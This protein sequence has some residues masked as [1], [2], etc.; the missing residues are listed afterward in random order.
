LKRAHWKWSTGIA[1]CLALTTALVLALRDENRRIYLPGRTSAGHHQIEDDCG[2]CHQ[3]FS[4]VEQRACL[5]C[6]ADE[7]DGELDAHRPEKFSDPR[8]FWMLERIDAKRCVS[9]HAEHKPDVTRAMSVTAPADFCIACHADVGK[10]RRSHAGFEPAGCA[11]TGC[12]RYHDNGALYEDFIAR[13]LGEPDTRPAP[14][15]HARNA[16]A[17]FVAAGRPLGPALARLASDAPKGT[18][19]DG[20]L[21]DWEASSHARAGVNCGACHAPRGASWNNHPKPAVCKGCHELES[22]GFLAGRHGMRLERGLS[23]MEPA[24]AQLP[25]KHRVEHTELG[26]SSCH[27]AH[28]FD[29][30][31]AAV[32]ACVACHDDRH[33]RAYA[34]TAHDRLWRAEVAGTAP[35]GSGVSCATCHLPRHTVRDHGN[36]LVRVQHNQNDNLRPNDKFVRS[37]CLSCHGLGFSFDALADA[38]LVARNFRGRP[39]RHLTTLEMVERRKGD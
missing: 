14:L 28:G 4:G 7:L 30:T 15:V 31:K 37:V 36:E 24:F 33:S 9:C 16:R 12:H 21:T 6:H 38:S 29:T 10:E 2:A 22:A 19:N 18:A 11:A 25:M 23:P 32:E 27:G 26:C 35:P 8:N 3:A 5:A 34:G 39:A 13:H 1:L 20:I 17:P